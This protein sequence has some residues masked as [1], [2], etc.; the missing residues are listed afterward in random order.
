MAVKCQEHINASLTNIH[1][2]LNKNVI[3]SKMHSI[4]KFIKHKNTSALKQTV[5]NFLCFLSYI[6]IFIKFRYVE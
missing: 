2:C 4:K 5:F 6:R 3:K 1:F